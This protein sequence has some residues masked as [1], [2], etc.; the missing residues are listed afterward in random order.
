MRRTG[1]W[2]GV[3]LCVAAGG[4]LDRMKRPTVAE[5]V[6]ARSFSP[7]GF[8]GLQP[9]GADGLYVESV[10]LERPVGDTFLDRDLWA[11]GRSPLP[12]EAD[13]VLAENGLRV[14]VLGGNLPP[15][16]Q[17]ILAS[18]AETVNPHSLTFANRKDA[19]IPTAGPTDLCE[20]DVRPDLAAKRTKVTLKQARC[21]VMVRP[22]RTADG[23]VKL[24]CEPQV[25]HGDRT[26][27]FRPNADATEILKQGEVPLERYPGLGFDVLL[28]PNEYLLIGWPANADATLGAALFGVEAD[29]RPRER[30][31]VIRAG[32]NGASATD[33]PPIPARRGRPS[34]AAEVAR[35]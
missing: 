30:V 24:W 32:V 25:Q 14:L 6:R 13:A 9:V 29:G 22:E 8:G 15:G 28:G 5:P 10:L 21:G 19:V 7:T 35:W 26:D 4:C 18:E 23:R 12:G 20:Y 34:I 33:L 16:F 2:A 27:W 11:A 17:K 31:L 3:L 1:A